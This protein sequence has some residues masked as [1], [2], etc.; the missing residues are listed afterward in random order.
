M[1]EK[2]FS[3][4]IPNLVEFHLEIK[5]QIL[6]FSHEEYFQCLFLLQVG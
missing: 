1:K 6:K 3:Y 5:E 4:K 2:N